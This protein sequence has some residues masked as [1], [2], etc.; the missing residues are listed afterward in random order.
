MTPSGYTGLPGY[1]DHAASNGLTLDRQ[2][3]IV[4]CEHGDRRVS[5]LTPGARKRT[6]ADNYQGR[7]FNS[8]NDCTV[9]PAGA[10]YFTDPPYG[11]PEESNRESKRTGTISRTMANANVTAKPPDHSGQ[12][13][14]A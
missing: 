10:I 11:L 7:R 3:R 9:D 2:G 1:S 6:L 14:K 5:V 8:P 4:F 12:I 13:S